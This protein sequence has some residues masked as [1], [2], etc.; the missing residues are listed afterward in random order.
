[1]KLGKTSWLILGIGIIVIALISL[2]TIYFQQ[3]GE[4]KRLNESLAAA[5][6]TMPQLTAERTDLESTLA[7]VEAR[8]ADIISRLEAGK[9]AYPS[10]V[11]SIEYDE[12]LFDFADSLELD[13]ALLES[14]EPG[15]EAVEVEIENIE[16]EAV[17]Y[18]V[19]SFIIDVRGEI[20]DI[21][22]FIHEIVTDEEFSTSTIELVDITIEHLTEEAKEGMTSD[23]IEKAEMPLASIRLIIYGYEGE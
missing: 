23:E 20:G 11:E 21:L 15:D 22:S 6:D 9:A 8:L 16:V 10:S 3:T 4:Q 18:F 19:T 17:T 12:A 7:E 14:E 13:I 2:Y 1:M 5:Q